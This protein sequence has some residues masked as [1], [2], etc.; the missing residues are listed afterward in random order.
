M[1]KHLAVYYFGIIL[2]FCVNGIA[3]VSKTVNYLPQINIFAGF[4]IAYYFLNKEFNI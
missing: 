1:E 2:L 4:C 3:I